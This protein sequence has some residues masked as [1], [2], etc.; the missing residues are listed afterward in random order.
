MTRTMTRAWIAPL[1]LASVLST[2]CGRRE[3][4]SAPPVRE[5][6]VAHAGVAS[7]PVEA[8]PETPAPPSRP[9]SR[10]SEAV[11]A[12]QRQLVELGFAPGYPDGRLGPDTIA[13]LREFEQESG[14]PVDGRLDEATLD[15]IFGGGVED[16]I[17]RVRGVDSQ[18]HRDDDPPIASAFGLGLA[19]GF[20]GAVLLALLARKAKSRAVT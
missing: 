6:P 12:V 5:D 3:R 1:L 16:E 9:P 10:P 20:L 2:G 8:P 15:A 19:L 11:R 13:A 4:T 7:A 14:L 18:P 17:Q